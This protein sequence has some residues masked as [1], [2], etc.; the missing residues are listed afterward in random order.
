[1]KK[2]L[3]ITLFLLSGMYVVAQEDAAPVDAAGS[4]LSA[5]PKEATKADADSA[6]I[7][8]DYTSAIQIYEALL[9]KGEAAEIYYN[10]GNSYFKADNLG[11]AIVNYERALL[12]RPGNGDFRANLEIAHNKTVD[13]VDVIPDVF[14]MEWIKDWRNSGSADAWAGWALTFFILFIVSLY[15]F[16]FSK[17][18]V[19]KKCGFV[20]GI[21]TLILVVITNL[22]ASQQK[23]IFLNRDKAI[24]V[25]PGVTVRSTP[26][27]SGTSLFV[28]HEGSKVII[29]D[30]SMKEWKEV[31]LEDGKVGWIPAADIEII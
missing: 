19:L 27:E 8:Q 16:V 3:F 10:L 24:V 14:F 21:L 7:R 13:K 22:F 15:F 20:C 23:S 11:K 5:N 9:E 28:L 6:Y 17:R 30:N 1:M 25:S 2:I 26:A 31:R 18:V 29:K 12:L 4:E